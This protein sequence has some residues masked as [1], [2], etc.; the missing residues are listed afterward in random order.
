M[1]QG[2]LYGKHIANEVEEIVKCLDSDTHEHTQ[3]EGI[4]PRKLTKQYLVPERTPDN[5]RYSLSSKFLTFPN[6]EVV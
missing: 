1:L 5:L 3:K 2:T 4:D 6:K